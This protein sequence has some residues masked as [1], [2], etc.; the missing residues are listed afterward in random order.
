MNYQLLSSPWR[1]DDEDECEQIVESSTSYDLTSS[2][3]DFSL[4]GG[5]PKL[6]L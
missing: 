6:H 1:S 2:T 3:S 5:E 4:Q